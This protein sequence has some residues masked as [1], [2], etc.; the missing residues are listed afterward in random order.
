MFKKFGGEKIEDVSLYVREYLTKH[1]NVTVFVGTDSVQL[2]SATMYAT[3]LCFWHNGH[4]V[5]VVF[6]RNRLP[7]TKDLFTRLWT[8]TEMSLKLAN[9]LK[10]KCG[11]DSVVDLDINPNEKYKS[12]VAHDAAVGMIKGY[13]F[14]VRTKPNAWAAS[15]AADLL[16]KG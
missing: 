16:C 5:H 12:N 11:V 6:E 8:E 1:P 3:A 13:G 4:G 7:K 14:E 15:V 9:E 2:R 10:E